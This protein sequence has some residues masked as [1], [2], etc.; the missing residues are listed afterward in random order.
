MKMVRPFIEC[1]VLPWYCDILRWKYR[2]K[3]FNTAQCCQSVTEWIIDKL[4]PLLLR[5]VIR[6]VRVRNFTKGEFNKTRL[7]PADLFGAVSVGRV[8]PAGV[9]PLSCNGRG[10]PLEVPIVLTSSL[11]LFVFT[12]VFVSSLV[13]SRVRCLRR[14]DNVRRKLWYLHKNQFNAKLKW[15]YNT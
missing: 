2:D 7:S 8:T 11:E 4:T 6:S 9:V 3:E 5:N 15:S 10:V 12:L 14:P 13:V 1:I